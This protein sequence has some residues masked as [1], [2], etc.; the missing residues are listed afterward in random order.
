MS[1]TA[2]LQAFVTA[3]L[4]DPD[5]ATTALQWAI[6][7]GGAD[8]AVVLDPSDPNYFDTRINPSV[9][10]QIP[11]DR[12]IQVTLSQVDADGGN[13]RQLLAL[14]P[15]GKEIGFWKPGL[16]GQEN[17]A[18]A[19]RTLAD[20]TFDDTVRTATFRVERLSVLDSGLPSNINPPTGKDFE[21]WLVAAQLEG[22]GRE[23]TPTRQVIYRLA[24]D[25]TV[26][27]NT[28]A[29]IPTP[30]LAPTRPADQLTS[31]GYIPPDW[32]G[33]PTGT[34][35][36]MPYEWESRSIRPIDSEEWGGFSDPILYGTHPSGVAPPSGGT[37]GA[38]GK[39]W[40]YVFV[41][42]MTEA[43]PT[44]IMSTTA[45]R[46]TDGYLPA[47]PAGLT[48][49]PFGQPTEDYPYEW[50]AVRK[51]D[52]TSQTWGEFSPWFIW[53]SDGADGKGWEY[54]FVRN[55]DGT[56][57]AQIMSTT[58]G[59]MM[60]DYVPAVPAGITDNPQ[61]ASAALPY[62]FA[63]VRKYD[64]SNQR[65]HE[66]FPWFLW[67]HFAPAGVDGRGRET[68]F[69]LNN[70]A[71]APAAPQTT[72]LEDDVDD[73][74]PAGWTDDPR[75]AREAQAFEWGSDRRTAPAGAARKWTKFG[76]PYLHHNWATDGVPGT[77][78]IGVNSIVRDPETGLVTVVYDAV[79][80]TCLVE[81]TGSPDTSYIHQG[82]PVGAVRAY[83][84]RARTASQISLPSNADSAITPPAAGDDLK[85]FAASAGRPT[86]RFG[87]IEV[88]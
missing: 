1:D 37:P 47:V 70:D 86:A 54:V 82:L 52:R 24:A 4:A 26:D 41:R 62:E 57:P 2:A 87:K 64:Q 84:V 27:M 10:P 5:K 81:D 20:P 13:N 72:D 75:G 67:T 17:N 16:S 61:G 14:V 88:R 66:F 56:V 45:G 85:G 29:Y 46:S 15:S 51:W 78:G 25:F 73:V 79:D 39:G 36:G 76:P 50:G 77:E 71:I 31:G 74:V 43:A 19:F 63:A 3:W 38:D 9:T 53:R 7:D 18:V 58:A 12:V 28:G 69:L 11:W 22:Y 55:A 48:D 33:D 65:W 35:L 59:Q 8:S 40:E 32:T 30:P 68:V 60:D 80:W 44:Q 23:D 49:R 83:R 42:T 6:V 21:V 34:R